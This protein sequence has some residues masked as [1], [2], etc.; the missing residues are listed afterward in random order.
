MTTYTSNTTWNT[1][2]DIPVGDW[3]II[4]LYGPGAGGQSGQAFRGTS[5]TVL[6]GGAGGG[7]GAHQRIT[8]SRVALD[9]ALPITFTLPAGGAGGTQTSQSTN[10]TSTSNNGSVPA[11]GASIVGTALKFFAGAGAAAAVNTSGAAGGG[12]ASSGS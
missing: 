6:D 5:S 1:D 11:S 4:D 3:F 2:A 7:A 10:G 9:A 12:Q 8:V